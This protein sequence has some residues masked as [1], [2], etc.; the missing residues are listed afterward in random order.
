MGNDSN[1]SHDGSCYLALKDN[2][3]RIGLYLF[4]SNVLLRYVAVAGVFFIAGKWYENYKADT[5]I[6]KFNQNMST[7]LE[8]GSS[9]QGN[10]RTSVGS[11][12]RDG[13]QL[14]L[15]NGEDDATKWCECDGMRYP[16]P[17]YRLNFDD[18]DS[19]FDFEKYLE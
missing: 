8:N 11:Y 6:E 15:E 1:S 16:K 18:R 17:T 12:R 7:I 3:N 5:L 19:L 9:S 14:A 10:V 13:R 4:R 2:S